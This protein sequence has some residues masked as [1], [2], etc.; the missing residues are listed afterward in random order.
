M[1]DQ[2]ASQGAWAAIA[3]WATGLALALSLVATFAAWTVAAATTLR[4]K[5]KWSAWGKHIMVSLVSEYCANSCYAL[6]LDSTY[7]E[8]VYELALPP[9]QHLPR[10]VGG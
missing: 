9:P 1:T 7:Y 6:A 2:L 4:T 5:P 8:D 3:P 10:L